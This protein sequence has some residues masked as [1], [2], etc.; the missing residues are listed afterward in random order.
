MSTSG[1]DVML[2]LNSDQQSLYTLKF[3]LISDFGF[4]F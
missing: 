1:F 3:L 2:S 4:E